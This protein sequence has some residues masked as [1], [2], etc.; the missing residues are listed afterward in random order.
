MIYVFVAVTFVVG[1]AL[2]GT[3]LKGLAVSPPPSEIVALIALAVCIVVLQVSF[4]Q[5]CLIQTVREMMTAKGIT[6]AVRARMLHDV[7]EGFQSPVKLIVEI[8]RKGLGT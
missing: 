3:G 8:I 2:G 5:W 7:F 4:Q 1:V 6:P